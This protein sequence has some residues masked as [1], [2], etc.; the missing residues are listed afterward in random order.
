MPILETQRLLIRPFRRTDLDAVYQ[1]LDVELGGVGEGEDGKKARA[2]RRQW[3]RWTVLNY[4]ALAE[5]HQ[6]PYGDRAIIRKEGTEPIIGVCGF[7]PVLLPFEQLPCF[8]L[9][10]RPVGQATRST[11][12][13][14]LY[15]AV[16]PAH[17]RR[18]YAAEA[19]AALIHYAFTEL[20]LKR[21]VAT[22]T[23]DNTASMGVMHRLGMR[24][25]RNPRPDPPWLQVAGVLDNTP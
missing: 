12:E 10:C 20:S 9:E 14:G 15:W 4:E 18:G 6:P 17:Q 22:T 21:I 11:S 2:K 5:L 3:L 24:I 7:A 16:A 19:G 8:F 23:Y 13:I 25:E 1:I